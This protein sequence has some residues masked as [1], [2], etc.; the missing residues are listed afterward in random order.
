MYFGIK[1]YLK[2]TTTT[3]SNILEFPWDIR[4]KVHSPS[5]DERAQGFL[6]V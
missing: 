5:T 4:K 2:T 6:A 3:L 1:N